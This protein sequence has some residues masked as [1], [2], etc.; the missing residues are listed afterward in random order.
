MLV[1]DEVLTALSIFC[2]LSCGLMKSGFCRNGCSVRF[3]YVYIIYLMFWLV[4]TTASNLVGLNTHSPEFLVMYGRMPKKIKRIL[5]YSIGFYPYREYV[6]RAN[7]TQ[8]I[9]FALN[10]LAIGVR[11][12]GMHLAPSG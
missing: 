12:Y 3:F 9:Q 11:R 6:N 7:N 1:I 2:L 8:V 5:K 4:Q 10:Q